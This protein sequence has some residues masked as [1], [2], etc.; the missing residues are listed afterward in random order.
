MTEG[1]RRQPRT[2]ADFEPLRPAEP[3]LLDER[4]T[5][6]PVVIGATRPEA[7]APPEVRIRAGFL[8]WVILGAEGASGRTHEKGVR[9]VGAFIESDGP[10]GAET[11]GLDL[12]GCAVDGDISLHRCRFEDTL[13]FDGAR[14][15][16]LY[17]DGSW[18]PGLVAERLETRGA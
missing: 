6:L 8:R 17:L 5:G 14:L 16:G 9:I 2:L 18:T 13:W 10:K 12:G 7:D 4:D 1:P 15:A 3:M 11:R